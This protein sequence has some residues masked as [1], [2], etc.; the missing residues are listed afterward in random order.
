VRGT[1]LEV[2]VQGGG[3]V[4][5][6]NNFNEGT[7]IAAGADMSDMIFQGPRRRVRVGAS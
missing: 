7:T 2:P 4:I 6:A 5:E 3:S 1:V